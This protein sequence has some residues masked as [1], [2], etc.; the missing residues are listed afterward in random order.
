M[1]VALDREEI[2]DEND[3]D[4]CSAV[5]KIRRDFGVP[6]VSVV[7]MSDIIEYLEKSGTFQ[8]HLE[9]M[10]SYRIKYGIK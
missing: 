6:V 4:R 9:S 5:M 8:E 10:K 3:T 1:I 2:A 7:G